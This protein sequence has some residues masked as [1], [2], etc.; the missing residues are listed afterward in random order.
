MS[1]TPE[2]REINI[3]RRCEGAGSFKISHGVQSCDDCCGTGMA[4]IQANLSNAGIQ[5]D[6][7]HGEG[8]AGSRGEIRSLIT[9]RH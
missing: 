9:R 3:C 7:K 4:Q 1:I 8:V 5:V 2:R 6:S